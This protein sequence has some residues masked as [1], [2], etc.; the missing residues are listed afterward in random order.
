MGEAGAVLERGARDAFRIPGVVDYSERVG[1]EYRGCLLAHGRR[2]RLLALWRLENPCKDSKGHLLEYQLVSRL[3]Q[4]P[5]QSP[6]DEAYLRG[7]ETHVTYWT[8]ADVRPVL[9]GGGK[10]LF[11]VFIF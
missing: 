3:L 11:D 6:D 1:R 5:C 8:E 10:S 7:S 2:N 4:A 9:G